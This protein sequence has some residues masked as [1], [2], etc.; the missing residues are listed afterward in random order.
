M[1]GD[2]EIV[3][4]S[5][6]RNLTF[7]L[8]GVPDV[9][10]S[11]IP[12]AK[13]LPNVLDLP[14]V[15][16]FVKQGIAAGTAELSVPKSMTLNLQE[17]LSG[18]GLG[19][20]R[21]KGVFVISIHYCEGLSAQD[22]NGFSDPYIVLAYAK[23][24]RPLYS[25][26]IITEDLNPVFEE[27]AFLMLTEDEVRAE[28]D[29][30]AMLWDS[31]KVG[32]DDLV[33]RVQIPVA[34]LTATP[35]RMFRRE[36]GLRGFDDANEMP[37]KLNWSIG[38]FEKADLVKEFERLPTADEA[39]AD[40]GLPTPASKEMLPNDAAP[41]PARDSVPPPPA[42]PMKTRP[43]PR[44]PSGV[45]SIVL[46]MVNNL[47]RQQL[48]GNKGEDREGE[49]GQDTDDPSEA[50]DNLPSGYGEFIVNDTLCYKTRVKQYTTNPYFEAGTE[51][52]IRDFTTTDVRIVIRD[53]RLR[54][55]DPIMGIVCLNLLDVFTDS[56]S[57]TMTYPIQEGVGFGK[58]NITMTFRG[59]QTTLPDNLR[60]WDTGTLTVSQVRLTDTSKNDD[61]EAR[62]MNLTVSTNEASETMKKKSAEQQGSEIIWDAEPLHLPVYNRYQGHVWFEFGK[63]GLGKLIGK[64]G[65]SAIAVL[66][67][68]D[69][70]D[71][72]DGE[73]EIPVITGPKM[74]TL[75]ANVINDQTLKHHKF[76]VV[77]TVR[78]RMEFTAGLD[79]YHEELRLSQSRRHALE[80]WMAVDG[81]AELAERQAS[82]ND[83]GVIDSK[84][85]KEMKKL[86]ERQ[87]ESHGR[88]KAQIGVYRSA[89]WMKRGLVDRLPGRK[90]TREPTVQSE[91]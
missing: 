62:E 46:H 68:Q 57:V 47:E 38:Y 29:I 48:E 5:F 24:G 39:K 59:V 28:E 60:G 54:E 12:M 73:V 58:A 19:D 18:S 11:A 69:L 15:S 41:L 26:R 88:G 40:Q 1:S 37:G 44:W 61:F 9:E 72:V 32:A 30:C 56:S 74:D 33:G 77:G 36:D 7:A 16:M 51:I 23:Y 52:F 22:K 31:D 79:F 14:F 49:A 70:T 67:L 43:D 17:M 6:V 76:T 63:G 87:L 13:A 83:D 10:V 91:A 34:E 8:C 66:W 89:K 78:V 42:D 21:A 53:S 27:T 50:T 86:H 84:E 71:F 4:T 20:V 45:L 3:D 80:A 85:K 75:K 2:V 90:K 25:T 65:P 81:E 35:N 64:G 55:N 82:F